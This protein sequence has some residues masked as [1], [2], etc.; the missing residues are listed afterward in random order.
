MNDYRDP[1]VPR[2]PYCGGTRMVEAFQTAYGAVSGTGHKLSGRPLYHSV[3]LKCGSVV[4]SFV[5][6]PEMLLKRRD[7]NR[8][9]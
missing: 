5:K 9:E 2:C 1:Y 8:E 7:R 4:R 6:E 3:C